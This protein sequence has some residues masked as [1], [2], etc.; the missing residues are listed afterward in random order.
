MMGFEELLATRAVEAVE[1]QMACPSLD[2]ISWLHRSV[3]DCGGEPQISTIFPTEQHQ[4]RD[5]KLNI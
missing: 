4:I 2:L 1:R 3:G 5:K